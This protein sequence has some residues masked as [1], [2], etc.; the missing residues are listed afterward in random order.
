M[1]ANLTLKTRV[2]VSDATFGI[3]VY[4][5]P[6]ATGG[7]RAHL[8]TYADNGG[9][10]GSGEVR[11]GPEVWLDAPELRELRDLLNKVLEVEP[12]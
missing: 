11:K 6:G 8:N 3:S 5:E 7:L 4:E 12:A 1:K 2:S 9:P 10:Y